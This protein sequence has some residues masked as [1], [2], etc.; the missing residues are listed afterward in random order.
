MKILFRPKRGTLEEAMKEMKEFH[1][2]QDL[3]DFLVKEWGNRFEKEDVYFSYYCYNERIDWETFI[4][5][6]GRSGD[7]DYLEKYHSPQAIGFL[8]FNDE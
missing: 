2:M 5:C 6:I 8:A 4:V 1:D 3:L 7:C